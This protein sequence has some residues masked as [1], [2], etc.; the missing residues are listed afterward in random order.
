[1]AGSRGF[2]DA[3]DV[4][5]ED[6]PHGRIRQ[7]QFADESNDDRGFGGGLLEEFETGRSVEEQPADAHPSPDW[8]PGR[9]SSNLRAA[10]DQH[11]VP[12]APIA[13]PAHRLHARDRGNA[14][15]RLAPE[16]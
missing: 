10:L 16:S 1:V 9:T 5:V 14:R 6:D 3:P 13:G 11:A 7:S 2:Q 4:D 12:L 8:T 15:Q